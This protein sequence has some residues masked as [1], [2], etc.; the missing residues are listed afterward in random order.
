M[1][2]ANA[3]QAR[4]VLFQDNT[5]RIQLHGL[6]DADTGVFINGASLTAT[7]LDQNRNQ[8]A[9]LIGVA[10]PY[11]SGTNG[12]YQGTVGASFAPPVGTNYTLIIDGDQGI[13][14]LHMEITAAVRVRTS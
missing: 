7:L 8:V 5:Q 11:V 6:R 4:V 9:G 1:P 13:S 14:H 3:T 12:N 2:I 10:M